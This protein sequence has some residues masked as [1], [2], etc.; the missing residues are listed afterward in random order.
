LK[1]GRILGKGQFCVVNEVN[2]KSM[3]QSNNSRVSRSSRGSR[4]G[5]TRSREEHRYPYVIKR[6]SF[7]SDKNSNHLVN[8]MIDLAYEAHLLSSLQ[9]RNIL[10]VEG[11]SS[12]VPSEGQ[13]YFVILS[14]LKESLADRIK[15]WKNEDES[16]SLLRIISYK[17]QK[18]PSKK[19]LAQLNCLLAVA[20]GI[21]YLHEQKYVFIG[22]RLLFDVVFKTSHIFLY[23]M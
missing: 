12:H 14:R 9:H 23:F 13:K 20:S 4:S 15:F 22:K 5:N 3:D 21:V 18:R 19:L 10:S 11:L 6:L 1:I 17:R 16:H 7:A 8:G 2:F